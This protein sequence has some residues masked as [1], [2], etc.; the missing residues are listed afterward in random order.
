VRKQ[1]DKEGGAE[2]IYCH[3]APRYVRVTS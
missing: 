3:V 1:L 2:R